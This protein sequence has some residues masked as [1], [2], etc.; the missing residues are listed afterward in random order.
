MLQV[1]DDECM[2]WGRSD[3]RGLVI[4]TVRAGGVPP[5]WQDRQRRA[6]EASLDDA[7]R[8][9]NVATQT[10][11][12]YPPERKSAMRDRLASAGAQRVVRLG[13]RRQARG[14]WRRT[15]RCSRC[16]TSCTGCRTRTPDRALLLLTSPGRLLRPEPAR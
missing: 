15:M 2:V 8:F 10:I 5:E 6:R 11:G 16:S 14:G 13:G 9:V 3:G 7:V 12:I 4:L 1:M